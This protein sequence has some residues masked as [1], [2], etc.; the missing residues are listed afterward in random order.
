MYERI[1]SNISRRIT[2]TEAEFFHFT[3]FLHHKTYKK[4]EFLHKAGEVSKTLSFVNEGCFRTYSIDKTGEEHILQFSLEDWWVG[5]AYS[6]LTHKPSIYYI[7][8][9]ED[10]DVYF[11]DYQYM[12][13]MYAEIPKFERFFRI[14]SQNRFIALEERINGELSASAEERYLDLLTRYPTLTQRVPQ[15]YI[16]SFLG[17]QPPSLSRIRKQLAEKN[18]KKV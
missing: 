18:R 12:E 7:E 15:Q 13:Q 14:L 6:A 11:I 16:A 3:T 9:L 17:I 8:A 5:D 1:Q 10:S 4:K 2:L